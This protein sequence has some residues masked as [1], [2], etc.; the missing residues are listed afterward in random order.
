MAYNAKPWLRR[1]ALASVSGMSDAEVEQRGLQI[2]L[3]AMRAAYTA[4]HGT[5]TP[6]APE[7]GK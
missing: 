4:R 1:A 3:D 6:V 5:P 7:H 2:R